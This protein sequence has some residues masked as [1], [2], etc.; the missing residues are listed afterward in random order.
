[1]GSA[2]IG[3]GYSVEALL[4][5]CIPDLHPHSFAFH[6]YFFF[7]KVDSDGRYVVVREGVVDIAFD[8]RC[9]TDS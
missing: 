4:S 6:L 3:L 2:V 9:F 5:G 1:M 8:E 7:L